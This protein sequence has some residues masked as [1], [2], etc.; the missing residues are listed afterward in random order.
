MSDTEEIPIINFTP[1]DPLVSKMTLAHTL[2]G[3]LN[4]PGN[5]EEQKE[6][7][8]KAISLIFHSCY[9]DLTIKYPDHSVH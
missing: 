4:N 1:D 7:I 6:M 9:M 5:T 8:R 3:D 2:I